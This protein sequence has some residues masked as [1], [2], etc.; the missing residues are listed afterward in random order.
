[1][2][3]DLVCVG[4]PRDGALGA[5][6]AEYERRLLHY[7]TYQAIEVREEN[8]RALVAEQV[9]DREAERLAARVPAG[10]AVV[11]CDPA[12]DRMDSAAFASWL[13]GMRD[14]AQ[15]VTFVIG[16][17]HGLGDAVRMQARRLLTLA[18]FTLPHELARLVL[19]EQL[20]RAG[21]I[22]RGEPYHK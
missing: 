1:M 8:A 19:V 14:R 2:R 20:Y 21:T 16:G 6:I 22:L 18:P 4:R 11:V 10:T 15:R 5:A 17:A 7:W 9:R 12:G 3:I 13:G